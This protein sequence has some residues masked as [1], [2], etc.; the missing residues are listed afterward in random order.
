MDVNR[1]QCCGNN[2]NQAH[3]MEF[4]LGAE[5]AR[6]DPNI[7]T[8]MDWLSNHKAEITCHKTVV[9]IPLL[10]SKVLRVLG[11]RPEEK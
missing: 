3:G 6:Q 10:D 4:M 5:E 2:G 8:G 1:G 7:I 11:E 9:R